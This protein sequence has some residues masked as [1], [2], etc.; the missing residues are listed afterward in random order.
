MGHA[1]LSPLS[2]ESAYRWSTWTA[3]KP[4][5]KLILPFVSDTDLDVCDATKSTDICL[6]VLCA[7]M[8]M[9]MAAQ[10]RHLFS[11]IQDLDERLFLKRKEDFK[12][13][14]EGRLR[15]EGI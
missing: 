5:Y 7:T 8:N 12:V 3:T 10:K 15:M 1:R 14:P 4:R 13:L 11:T 6:L 9:F 2:P